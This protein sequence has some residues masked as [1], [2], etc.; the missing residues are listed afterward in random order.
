[1]PTL[2]TEMLEL[3]DKD[4]RATIIKMFQQAIMNMLETSENTEHLSKEIEDIKR[5]KMEVME[6]KNIITEVK[7]Q[8]MSSTA[9][10]R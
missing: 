2:M 8:W 1:M 7:T 3:L 10:R 4:F 5:N 9:E 6:L